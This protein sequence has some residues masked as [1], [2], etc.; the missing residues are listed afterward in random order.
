MARAVLTAAFAAVWAAI[1]AIQFYYYFLNLQAA[2]VAGAGT[3]AASAAAA[4]TTTSAAQA[5]ASSGSGYEFQIFLTLAAVGVLNAAV[6]LI[7]RHLRQAE[8]AGAAGNRR[9]PDAV[10]FLLLAASGLLVLLQG[11]PA[12]VD[13][14][15]VAAL[16]AAAFSALPGAATGTFFL[17]MMTLIFA[18]RVHGGGGAVAGAGFFGEIQGP[19]LRVLTKVA[20]GAAA[21]LVFLVTVAAFCIK[22]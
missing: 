11:L 16:G 9:V 20:A 17:G 2:G 6:L 12:A 21:A 5:S 4:T 10:A 3:T 19:L 14:D 22:Y 8:A 7:H 15:V 1:N 18:A 13:D